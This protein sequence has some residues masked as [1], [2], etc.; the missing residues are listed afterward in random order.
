MWDLDTGLLTP[1]AAR[2]LKPVAQELAFTSSEL[3]QLGGIDAEAVAGRIF[4]GFKVGVGLPFVREWLTETGLRV[5][6]SR[7]TV[8][9]R[10]L[11]LVRAAVETGRAPDRHAIAVK[12][13]GSRRRAD[14]VHN[15]ISAIVEAAGYPMAAGATRGQMMVAVAA[16]LASAHSPAVVSDLEIVGA[17]LGMASG[18]RDV[19]VRRVRTWVDTTR[20]LDSPDGNLSPYSRYVRSVLDLARSLRRGD[21]TIDIA[22]VAAAAFAVQ[23]GRDQGTVAAS[24][25]ERAAVRFWLEQAGL[26]GLVDSAEAPGREPVSPFLSRTG[27]RAAGK[28]LRLSGDAVPVPA[29]GATNGIGGSDYVLLRAAD[30]VL[31]GQ[32]VS[33]WSLAMEVFATR[34]PNRTETSAI[35]GILEFGGLGV[36]VRRRH[37]VAELLSRALTEAR[38]QLVEGR[39]IDPALIVGRLVWEGVE[40]AYLRN[41]MV[42]WYGVSGLMGGS[43]ARDGLLGR[44]RGEAREAAKRELAEGRV[45]DAVDIARS[46]FEEPLPSA[47]QIAVVG[48]WLAEDPWR[49]RAV[50]LVRKTPRGQVSV[51][52]LARKV[53]EVADPTSHELQQVTDWLDAEGLLASVEMT[54]EPVTG[55]TEVA[56]SA[57]G[58]VKP[59]LPDVARFAERLAYRVPGVGPHHGASLLELARAISTALPLAPKDLLGYTHRL[60][61]EHAPVYRGHFEAMLPMMTAG[62]LERSQVWAYLLHFGASMGLHSSVVTHWMAHVD[63]VD[64][65][66]VRL[67]ESTPQEVAFLRSKASGYLNALIGGVTVEPVPV[68]TNLLYEERLLRVAVALYERG[69]RAARDEAN[70]IG[71]EMDLTGPTRLVGGSTMSAEHLAALSEAQESWTALDSTFAESSTTATDLDDYTLDEAEPRYSAL[72]RLSAEELLEQFDLHAYVHAT[73]E[74]G[75]WAGNT[76]QQWLEARR[77]KVWD[78]ETGDMTPEAVRALKPLART[79]ALETTQ[80]G[81][82]GG[83]EPSA[84][85]ARLF[86]PARASEGTPTMA[87]WLEEA[88]I[89][90]LSEEEA[91]AARTLAWTGLTDTGGSPTFNEIMREVFSADDGLQGPS[92]SE[93]VGHLEAAGYRMRAGATLHQM[94]VAVAAQ[95]A[96]AFVASPVPSLDIVRDLLKKRDGDVNSPSSKR[97]RSWWD[98]TRYLERVG[99]TPTLYARFVAEV[100]TRAQAL[101]RL[102]GTVDI[103]QV[104]AETF[105]VESGR[106]DVPPEHQ[107]AAVKFWLEGAGV[108]GLVDSVGGADPASPRIFPPR[109]HRD[110]GPAGTIMKLTRGNPPVEPRGGSVGASAQA[111][112]AVWKA[113]E[114]ATR[115]ERLT[116]VG[117]SRLVF[118]VTEPSPRQSGVTVGLLEATGLG[119]LVPSRRYTS[120]LMA[121]AFA[122]ARNAMRKGERPVPSRISTALLGTN[123]DGTGVITGWLQAMGFIDGL[124]DPNGPI[125]RMRSLV[126]SLADEERTAGREP[127]P[128]D[129]ARRALNVETPDPQQIAV[130]TEW[131]EDEPLKVLVTGVARVVVSRNDRLT[132]GEI[133]TEV[134]ARVQVNAGYVAQIIDWLAEAGLVSVE[135]YGEDGRQWVSDVLETDGGPV[136]SGNPA[137]RDE[138]RTSWEEGEGAEQWSLPEVA[139]EAESLIYQGLP[140]S[141]VVDRLW[142][143]P[144]MGGADPSGYTHRLMLEH[145]SPQYRQDFETM[146]HEVLDD[147]EL[148]PD[149]RTERLETFARRRRMD[150]ATVALWQRHHTEL[151]A[152]RS[153]WL[154]SP[155]DAQAMRLKVATYLNER[156]GV[157]SVAPRSVSAGL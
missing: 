131:L 110:S 91:L 17:V 107:R 142:R 36:L 126:R 51:P 127:G 8:V 75:A 106:P 124:V 109:V 141:V 87:D 145:A 99:G 25:V 123:R 136:T 77:G 30:L 157:V 64:A 4:D 82:W 7:E 22:E 79:L 16:R 47:V 68:A 31:Q 11:Y 58:G 61:L 111:D 129:L 5:L 43:A 125:G 59:A 27:R 63:G 90:V 140:P 97:V 118:A 78:A 14:L 41:A 66:R 70:E 62:R 120:P 152:L 21:G 3:G 1:D 153:V 46:V 18:A 143:R 60:M 69:D 72:D 93:A 115:R 53:F 133:L 35:E 29:A 10:V 19:A 92:L 98:A 9:A 102:D 130:V 155:Q 83:V 112:F 33:V 65:L 132:F 144:P 95:E 13:F 139:R 148:T 48:E 76:A 86:E 89:P 12:V 2:L 81:R 24:S 49:L 38:Q 55:E 84:L 23:A 108:D 42:S 138:P 57:M 45:P 67:A 52:S 34:K 26:S 73:T 101:R 100:G 15:E 105:A 103:A 149:E 156:I 96:S 119:Y 94:V 150:P 146:L 117:L 80:L 154:M 88:G 137:L 39:E 121:R 32:P 20:F 44:L 50:A 40:P 104:A 147:P 6:T 113:S 134:L 37:P 135:P 56:R 151:A 85:A 54:G 116:I 71:R 28:I 122:E 114:L 128:V 74:T